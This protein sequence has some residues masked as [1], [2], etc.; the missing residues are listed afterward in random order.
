MPLAL[1]KFILHQVSRVGSASWLRPQKGAD[2]PT[3]HHEV[4]FVG[5]RVAGLYTVYR[6]LQQDCGI[7]DIVV[8]E[9]RPVV[10]GRIT[11]QRDGAGDPLFNNVGWRVG[12]VNTEMMNLPRSW[13]S[14]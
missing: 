11:T 10:G 2:T 8:L 13:A 7:T 14:P 12:E 4:I 1:P 9:G 5:G 3:S 6:L